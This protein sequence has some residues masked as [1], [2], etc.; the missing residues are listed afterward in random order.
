MANYQ[1]PNDYFVQRANSFR[2]EME[3]IERKLRPLEIQLQTVG[4]FPTLT[5]AIGKLERLR[6]HYRNEM[7]RALAN[8]PGSVKL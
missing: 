3:R 8:A 1:K 5:D 4:A 7:T 6:N 2:R